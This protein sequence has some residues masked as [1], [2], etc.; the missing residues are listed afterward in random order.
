[1]ING[2]IVAVAV[3]TIS[4]PGSAVVSVDT[5]TEQVVGVNVARRGVFTSL[6]SGFSFVAVSISSTAGNLGIFE[7]VATF[8]IRWGV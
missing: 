3:Q 7:L 6:V 4:E 8:V 1:M 5:I 2:V